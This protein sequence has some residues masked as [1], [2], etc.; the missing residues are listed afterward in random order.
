MRAQHIALSFGDQKIYDDC[1][2]HF[3]AS[4]KVGIVGVNGAG[5]STL[6]KVILGQQKLDDVIDLSLGDPDMTTP[7]SIID[8]AFRD[9][10]AGHTKYTDFRGDPEVR[11]EIC[12]YYEKNFGMSVKDDARALELR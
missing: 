3:D 9:A 5:K 1:S 2:F 10:K 11:A 12:S 7:E 4:D 8:A 6:F